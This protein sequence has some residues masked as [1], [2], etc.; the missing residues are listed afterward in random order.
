[1][2]RELHIENFALIESLNVNFESGLN[3]ITG[4]TGA[5][6]SIILG[7]MGL[8][9]GA[10]ADAAQVKSGARNCVVEMSFELTES[11]KELFDSLDI[12]WFD[13]AVIRRTIS[14]EGRS[15]A[16]VN[17]QPITLQDLKILT[18][19]LIDI[20]SQ[21]QNLL[22]GDL[23]FQ[24]DLVDCVAGNQ[25]EL[26]NYAIKYNECRA[27][28]K[29]LDEVRIEAANSKSEHDYLNFQY[30]QLAEAK[31]VDGELESLE[32]ESA[33][34]TYASEI[35]AVMMENS[36]VLNDSESAVI[37]QLKGLKNGLSRISKWLPEAEELAERIEQC[38]VEL[39]DIASECDSHS[40]HTYDDPA[41][42][43][44]V[45]QR[46]DKLYSLQQKHHTESVAELI[47]LRDELR[48]KLD[49][50]ESY[51]DE[52]AEIESQLAVKHGEMQSI[53]AKISE[54]RMG[55][56]P[57]VNSFVN[58][59]LAQ[60]GMV[61]GRFDIELTHCQPNIKG[62]DRIEFIFSANKNQPLQP[63]EKIASG[64]EMARVMLVI[65]AL[66]AKYKELPTVIFDEIDQGISGEIAH[67]T[68]TL[69]EQLSRGIQV[70]NITHL[71]QI[72]AKGETH[73]LVYK[74]DSQEDTKTSI[75]KLTREQ[76]I[77]QIAK[78]ISGSDMTEAARKQAENLLNH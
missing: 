6:K 45:S 10:K 67:K 23:S 22:L 55:A 28:E 53:A 3:T 34:L 42:L 7:A 57:E 1:M 56:I 58:E 59:N 36:A 37:T 8:I 9:L 68:G 66:A 54:S 76:R 40:A 2:L 35:K 15:R 52:I 51:D 72:A 26:S 77:E 65:K 32:Q 62:S 20:H 61:N 50:I 5:G 70:I 27:L 41:R 19:K 30:T 69:I 74:T 39:K 60:L 13:T 12:E 47:A 46:L 75:V 64:G 43:E 29:Q 24:I 31:L 18:A 14:A 33:R 25:T 48:N 16:Y 49:K 44:A 11:F 63:L 21:H 17:D 38:T 78:M 73:F 71:P 4:E